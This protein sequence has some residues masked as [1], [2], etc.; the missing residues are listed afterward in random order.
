LKALKKGKAV[1]IRVN[2]ELCDLG[3]IGAHI[4]A[5][6]VEALTFE[7]PEGKEVYRHST[8]HVMAHAVK[9]L[10]PEAK[11]AIGPAIED[12]FYYDFDLENPLTPEDLKAIEKEMSRIIKQN[13]PFEK[14]ELKRDEA[15]KLLSFWRSLRTR[16]FPST[17]R[18]VSWTS[19]GARTFPRRAG[20]PHLNC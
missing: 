10:M 7:S 5:G 4:E 11:L 2:G 20:W 3:T 13:S 17:R 9:N 8:S 1:A 18:A 19:A 15:I 12:G 6:S 14:K 16:R